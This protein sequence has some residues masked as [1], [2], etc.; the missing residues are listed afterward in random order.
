MLIEDLDDGMKNGA[1]ISPWFYFSRYHSPTSLGYLQVHKYCEDA[2]TSIMHSQ[3]GYLPLLA[4]LS[5]A[6]WHTSK[7][8]ALRQ[9]GNNTTLPAWY[10]YLVQIKRRNPAW[11]ASLQNHGIDDFSGRTPRAGV[12]VDIRNC[13]EPSYIL[14]YIAM[15]VPVWFW[16]GKPYTSPL[17]IHSASLKVFC[18]TPADISHALH[19]GSAVLPPVRVGSQQVVGETWQQFFLQVEKENNQKLVK[20]TEEQCRICEH[21]VELSSMGPTSKSKVFWW[22]PINRFCIRRLVHPEQLNDYLRKY[23]GSQ[24]RFDPVHDEWDLCT[25]FDPNAEQN[26]PEPGESDG[27]PVMYGSK[28]PAPSYSPQALHIDQVAEDVRAVFSAINCEIHM[29]LVEIVDSLLDVLKQHYGLVIT[30]DIEACGTLDKPSGYKLHELYGYYSSQEELSSPVM[31]AADAFS[32]V[33]IQA[34]QGNQVVGASAILS[35]LW[36]I[37]ANNTTLSIHGLS[38]SLSITPFVYKGS[39]RYH[40]S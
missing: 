13:S 40:R 27:T 36:D 35:K 3:D 26:E 9:Y 34:G 14:Q 11:L 6:I 22:E 12:I 39:L 10:H 16:C 38:R 19:V 31:M 24:R 25:E 30:Q 1:S 15:N 17:S 37:H 7:S 33:L 21:W 28:N 5:M 4:L 29:Q 32:I 18:P 8:T 20:Q 2:K 23:S